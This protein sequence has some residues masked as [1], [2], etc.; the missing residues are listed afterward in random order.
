MRIIFAF[1][2]QTL[3]FIYFF[4]ATIRL[5]WKENLSPATP[6][7][8]QAPRKRIPKHLAV[9]FIIDPNIHA[10]TVQTA[11]TES[12]LKLV[13]WCQTVGISKLTLYEEH[14]ARNKHHKRVLRV[15]LFIDRL[16]KCAQT[17]QTHFYTPELEAESSE[18]EIEYPLTPPPSDY[19]D[20]RPLSPNHHQ[21][22][23]T[24]IHVSQCTPSQEAQNLQ[25]LGKRRSYRNSKYHI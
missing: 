8:L 24:I 22:G 11:L 25:K 13:E 5:F 6:K 17:L 15:D 10:D 4:L 23:L 20:S 14:G 9:A 19:S 7:P 1:L 12:A 18:S 3:H 21:A 2:L 16:S